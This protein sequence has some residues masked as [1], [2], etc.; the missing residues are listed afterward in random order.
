MK[1]R[2]PTRAGRIA[3]ADG[4]AADVAAAFGVSLG[5]VYSARHNHKKRAH[6]GNT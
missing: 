2:D 1:R 4:P 5:A 6:H 3:N